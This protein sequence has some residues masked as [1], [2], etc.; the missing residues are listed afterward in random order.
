MA[1]LRP[2]GEISALCDR[3]SPCGKASIQHPSRLAPAARNATTVLE[4]GTAGYSGGSVALRPLFCSFNQ[5][6]SGS[7]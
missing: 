1:A 4:R 5:P 2:A 7:K 3:S 6:R